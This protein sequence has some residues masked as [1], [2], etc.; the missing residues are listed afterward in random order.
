ML[1][2]PPGALLGQH[3]SCVW[4]SVEE[5]R[6]VGR[7]V[8][9]QL[10][11]GEPVEIERQLQRRDGSTF[12]CRLLARAVDPTHP[13]QGGTIW[14]AEDVTERRQMDMTLAAARD[15][16]EAANRAKSAFL[17]NTSHEL[18]TPLNAL[19]GL[20]RL[21]RQP[22]VDEI[23][24]RD[25]IEQISDSA[26]TLSAIIADILDLSRIEAGKL[27]LEH[28]PFRLDT[29]LDGLHRGY[30]ALADAQGLTMHLC[31]DP[32]VP[33]VVLGDSVRLRQILSNYLNNALK[34]TETGSITLV[35][36]RSEGQNLLFE[37][38]DTGPG[39]AAEFQSQLFVPFAQ[40]D[41]SIQRRIGGTGL[42]LSI[43]RQLAELMSGEVGLRSKP[44]QGS[45]FWA[46]L[47]LPDAS[48]AELDES[49]GADGLDPLNGALVLM[50]E[51]NPVN[52]MIS[53]ALLEQWGAEVV[54][55]QGGAEAILAVDRAMASGHPFDVVLMDVQMPEMSGHEATRRLR[56]HH[57]AQALP[58]IALTAAALVA[59]REQALAEGMNDFLTKPIDAMRLRATLVRTLR[60]A[61]RYRTS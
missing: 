34:F 61:A 52:M 19:L 44:G 51:D 37:V 6:A 21:A 12:V 15:A 7:D 46:R 40:V 33:E 47:P 38:R 25:Y 45:T 2:W 58:I 16:A 36:R 17:A 1:G 27:H 18:R 3:A 42:G 39:I 28:L 57:S 9:D 41:T 22:E 60:Q 23:R 14:L 54:Q 29:L 35:V 48:T 26:E 4:P 24:R 11:S 56:Q 30:G 59:E 8:G 20:A 53:V 5:H 13:V 50:V 31:C 10:R 55:A 32:E 43:C 49:T